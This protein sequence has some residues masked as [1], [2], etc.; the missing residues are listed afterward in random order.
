RR[1]LGTVCSAVRRRGLDRPF[2][3]AVDRSFVL[4]G[5]G[6]VVTGTVWSGSV[7]QGESVQWLPEGSMVTVRGLQSHGQAAERIERGQR[8][9]MNLI[10]VH[11]QAIQRGHELAAPGYLAPSR[12]LTVDVQ[13]LEESPWPLRHRMRARLHLGTQE[14][15]VTVRLL[16]G[17]TVAPGERGPAQLYA[18]APTMATAGQP[19][20]LRAE[21]PV[22]TIG[23]GHVLQ[24]VARPI[25][26][27]DAAAIERLADFR[28]ADEA[29][30]V[31]AAVAGRL[32]GVGTAL[33]LCRDAD[34]AP[35]GA[36]GI[37]TG[38]RDR[39]VLV[40]LE[41]GPRR[42]LTLHRDVLAGVE[43]KILTALGALHDA[44]PLES[45]VARSALLQRLS[46]LD[47]RLVD[48]VAARLRDRGEL[49]GDEQAMALAGFAP[50]LSDAQRRLRDTAVET[51]RNAGFSPPDR[52]ELAQAHGLD[53]ADVQPIL[54]LCASEGRLHHVA[55]GLFLH[56]DWDDELRRRVRGRLADGDAITMAGLRDLLGTSRKYAV[57]IGE[58]LDRIGLTRRV[59]DQRVLAGRPAAG[60][61]ERSPS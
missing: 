31:A 11:H 47:P 60:A 55:G 40:E 17:T 30:R 39:G 53:E 27:R 46:Y 41:T 18:A 29:V 59:G 13:V 52:A 12:L 50:K 33:E 28:A 9:A 34:V 54:D 7:Q 35:D 16:R 43:Q 8:A 48:G 10:G 58:Y 25:R 36:A 6:T 19:F 3:M 56:A 57:P 20:V 37:V 5:R 32:E 44:A 24:P 51:F 38:L 23:G 21:S 15:M 22:L 4:Q 26:R 49:V 61:G 1:T 14:V 42:V 45:R 2:R